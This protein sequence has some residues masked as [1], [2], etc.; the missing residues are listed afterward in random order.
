MFSYYLTKIGVPRVSI[1]VVDLE[2][3]IKGSVCY[4]FFRVRIRRTDKGVLPDVV[5]PNENRRRSSLRMVRIR[6]TDEGVLSDGL[7]LFT[8]CYRVGRSY[9]ALLV[10]FRRTDE[11]VLW[12]L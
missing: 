8:F 4:N 9:L 5:Y 2:I 6:R 10:R 11:G 3:A 7:C 12:M 1:S